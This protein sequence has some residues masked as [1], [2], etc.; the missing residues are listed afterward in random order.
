MSRL[1]VFGSF[2][3]DSQRILTT[4]QLLAVVCVKLLLE[5][6]CGR[7]GYKLTPTGVAATMRIRELLQPA[8][9]WNGNALCFPF[10]SKTIAVSH[11]SSFSRRGIARHACENQTAPVPT[12][13]NC[14]G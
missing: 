10:W 2:A 5:I 11:A 7:L 6:G 4:V 13:A 12:A 14:S 9:H 8:T 1:L 3:H